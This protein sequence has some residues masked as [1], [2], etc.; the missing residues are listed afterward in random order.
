M[1]LHLSCRFGLLCTCECMH[2]RAMEY[3][4]CARCMQGDSL[5]GKMLDAVGVMPD[6]V[7]VSVLP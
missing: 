2:V 5:P 6:H 1:I 3:F 4:F 7:G